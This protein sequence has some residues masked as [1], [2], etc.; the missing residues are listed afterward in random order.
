MFV[1]STD[2]PLATG[3]LATP[4]LRTAE[5]TRLPSKQWRHR[6]CLD[7]GWRCCAPP[8]AVFADLGGDGVGAERGAGVERHRVIVRVLLQFTRQVK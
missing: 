7:Q 4:N 6:Q 5:V 2:S 8:H 3:Q 1:I